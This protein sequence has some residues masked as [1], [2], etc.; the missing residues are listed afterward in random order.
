[1]LSPSTV[2]GHQ[3][4]APQTPLVGK[5]VLSNVGRNWRTQGDYCDVNDYY[6]HWAIIM[7][8]VE[9]GGRVAIIRPTQGRL[10]R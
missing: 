3:T 6:N 9:I 8:W 2:T 5:S 7:M 1:M 4:L 10:Y